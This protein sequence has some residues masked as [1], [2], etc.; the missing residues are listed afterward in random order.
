MEIDLPTLMVAG[1]FVAAISGVFLIF[2]WMQTDH[3]NGML[4]WAAANLVLAAAIPMIARA[5]AAPGSPAVVVAITLLNTSPA[6]IWASARATNDRKI[7]FAV[8]GSGAVLWL[9]AYA[10]PL[11]RENPSGQTGLNLAIGSTFLLA[12]AYEFWRG[13]AERLMARWPLIVLLVL[14]GGFSAVGALDAVFSSTD[15]SALGKLHDWFT[16]IH[17]ETLAFVVGT[18]IFTVA[19][20]RERNEMM[21]KTAAS[22]D[23]LTGVATR[24]VFYERGETMLAGA[25][26]DDAAFAII[27]F[28]LDG[29]KA[30]NDTYG[31]GPGDE[32][33]R[34]FGEAT[35]KTLRASDLI[36]RLGGE[37]FGALLPGASIGA[38]YVA[39]DRIRVAF[40]A[41]CQKV[42]GV[43]IPATVS[44][45]IAHA[46]PRSTLDSLIQAADLALYRAKMQGRD[47][48]EV[49]ERDERKPAAPANGLPLARKVA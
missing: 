8:V 46:H 35:L 42:Q 49:A 30:I 12:A 22:T 3:A 27:L 4:W 25:L 44:A 15:A 21:H 2:S 14:H 39:A 43:A 45:G 47:R 32:V 26:K 9:V 24:R 28:D 11:F 34:L 6:L 48:V 20:A 36:G 31:H 29:F 7:D 18:S 1:S 33:L 40:A 19:M 23:A 5:D 17:F 16:F 10:M 37:E 13:R 41:A 38:A